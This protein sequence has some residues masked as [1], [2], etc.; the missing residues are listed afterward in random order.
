[1]Q[2]TTIKARELQLGDKVQCYEGAYSTAT[3]RQIEDG[4][5]YLVR[6]YT[7]TSDYE[8]SGGLT[9]Y[10]GIE[11]FTVYHDSD[12]EWILLDRRK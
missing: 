3:V 1:M 11:E 4:I 7:H 12:R 5:V 2:P 9:C 10:V 8:T 6:P